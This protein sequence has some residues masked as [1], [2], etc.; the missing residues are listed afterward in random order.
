MKTASVILFVASVVLML[1][2]TNLDGGAVCFDGWRSHSESRRGT[3]SWHGGVSRWL[4]KSPYHDSVER[5]GSGCMAGAVL[6]F[7]VSYRRSR[8][9]TPPG[10]MPK[11]SYWECPRCGSALVVRKSRKGNRQVLGCSRFP[12]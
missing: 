5:T 6:L 7:L 4:V 11:P 9:K 12:A 2:A 1:V 3:C 8:S 10:R